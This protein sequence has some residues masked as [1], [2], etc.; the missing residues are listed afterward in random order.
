VN[1]S[2]FIGKTPLYSRVA[3]APMA[4]VTDVVFRQ[5]VRQWAP[6]ALVCTEMIS[7]NGLVQQR[8]AKKPQHLF[9]LK[10]TDA[11]HPIAY[12]L[13]AHDEAVLLEAAEAILA[14]HNPVSIDLNMGCPVKKITGNFEGCALMKAPEQAAK[15]VKT[16]ADRLPVP[17]TVKFRLGWDANSINYLDFGKRLEDAGAS[18]VTLHARTRAQGYAP[19]CQWEAF[20]HL[21]QALRI[22]VIANGDINTVADARHVIETYGVDGV[23]IGR[24]SLG[25]PW[26]VGHIE[27]ALQTGQTPTPLT[28]AE[29]F[30]LAVTHARHYVLAKQ[31]DVHSV[32]EATAMRDMRKHMAWYAYDFAGASQCRHQLT[33]VTS[34]AQVQA[35]FDQVLA[36]LSLGSSSTA[37]QLAS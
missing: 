23:M 14:D 37:T 26:L 32:D 3:L 1:P 11:D 27:Q 21:K 24:G 9:I 28:L 30:A 35:I 19:G 6:H 12:Q 22:P 29:Q 20:G 10:Q 13:A 2:F 4:G 17:I 36:S 25:K 16:L 5:L 15:L 33:Q 34:V 18:M 31:T 8:K 7:S